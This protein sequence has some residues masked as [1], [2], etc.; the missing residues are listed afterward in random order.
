MISRPAA[1]RTTPRTL[2]VL[3]ALGATLLPTAPAPAIAVPPPAPASERELVPGVAPGHGQP[4]QVDTPDQ[5]LAP[6][7]YQPTPG[8]DAVEPRHA[9]AG[10]Y[11]PIEYVPLG[12]A[13]ARVACS[14]QAGPYQRQVERWLKLRVDGRQSAADCGAIRAFQKKHGI[15]PAIG[16]AGPVTWAHMQLISAR[17]NP[18]AAGKCPVRTHKVACVDLG[19]QLTWVQQG[20][21]V[22]FGPVPVR[23]GRA[24]YRTRSGWHRIYWRHKNHV[25]TLYG[26]PMPYSQFFSGGQA[27]H[28][29]Y[30]SVFSTVGSHGC[31]N[32]RLGDARRLWGVLKKRDWVYVWGRRPGS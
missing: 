21:K 19:R 30:G 28:A 25:S 5:Q 18:N 22:V 16:F 9:P 1:R 13:A 31:V 23:S 11:A 24:G 8:E 7:V 2:A 4:W 32:L 20:R 14:R 17:K 12:E 6:T 27:F 10:A 26:T 3:L 29:S 15:K